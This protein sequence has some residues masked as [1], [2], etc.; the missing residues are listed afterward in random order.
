M[1]ELTLGVEESVRDMLAGLGLDPMCEGLKETP[2]RVAKMLR[3][4]TRGGNLLD[5]L[6]TT[7][8]S[9]YDGA[10]AQSPLIVQDRIPFRGLCEHHLLPFFGEAAVGYI[11]GKRVVGLSKLVRVVQAAGT[12]QPSIQERITDAI[13]DAIMK[14]LE[15]EGVIVVVRAEHTCMAV[16]GVNSPGVRT[17]TSALRGVFMADYA[18]RAEFY[19]LTGWSK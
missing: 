17:L 10:V 7:F 8:E 19:A 15:A 11:P 5:E 14:G 16:R 18:A 1:P 3:D 9:P 6:G 4:F 13:A 12:Q 2:R